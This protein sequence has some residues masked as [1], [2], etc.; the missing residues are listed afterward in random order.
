MARQHTFVMTALAVLGVSSVASAAPPVDLG[1][2]WSVTFDGQLRPRF[3][4]H[5]GKDFQADSTETAIVTQRARLGATLADDSGLA[6]TLRLQDVRIW[7][8]EADTLNDYD[9]DGFD[10]HEAFAVVPIYKPLTLKIGRQEI[11]FDNH[12]LVGNVGWTQRA[13]SF[14]AARAHWDTSDKKLG[15]DLVYA[16]VRESTGDPD[17]HVPDG[18]A[19]DTD[20]AGAHATYNLT[21]TH[22]LSVA[23]YTNSARNPTD[24]PNEP[25]TIR[26]TAGAYFDGKVDGLVYTFEGYYQFGKANVQG[27]TPLDRVSE[28]VSTFM[29]AGRIG[30]T[31][32]MNPKPGAMLWAEYLHGDG[33][34]EGTFDTLYATNHKFY[35]EMDFFLNI[36]DDTGNRGL[37]DLGGKVGVAPTSWFATN[38]AFHHLRPAESDAP[39]SAFGNEL[40]LRLDFPFHDN[41]AIQSMFGVFLPGEAM[42]NREQIAEDEDLELEMLAYVTLDVH[43]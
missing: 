29:A 12:R 21:D 19:G 5:S 43:F 16:K 22:A 11:I 27:A 34:A 1:Q 42:R 35:G 33:T 13:R 30:Y 3:F 18:R 23:F 41:A 32:A 31:L 9:A 26:H 40:D 20:F 25:D 24:T 14:D 4:A 36:P 15:V 39:G 38:L 7:G 28:T 37:V 17:G 2:G 10:V 6:L 8:E